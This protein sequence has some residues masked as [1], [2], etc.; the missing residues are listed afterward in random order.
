MSDLK[1]I[2][3]YFIRE[4][5]GFSRTNY[6]PK[7]QDVSDFEFNPK[8]DENDTNLLLSTLSKNEKICCEQGKSAV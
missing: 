7:P 5:T 3:D 8:Y 4:H 2:F 6:S 1:N